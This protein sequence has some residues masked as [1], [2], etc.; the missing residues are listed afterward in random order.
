MIPKKGAESIK[1]FRPTSLIGSNYKNVTK[2]L[3][4]RLQKVFPDL[5][6]MSQAAFVNGRLILD[7][8]LIA[9]ETIHSRY[10]YKEPGPM[11]KFGFRK[12]LQQ[13]GLGLP[14]AYWASA[15]N[16]GSG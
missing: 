16:E 8:V 6:S 15:L 14:S 10:R 12:S 3:A 9:N 1:D 4:S 7:S 11:C 13:G 5:I 2:V